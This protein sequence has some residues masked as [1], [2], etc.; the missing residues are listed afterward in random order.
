MERPQRWECRQDSLLYLQNS[1]KGQSILDLHCLN[2]HLAHALLYMHRPRGI[3]KLPA[4]G[5]GARLSAS[6]PDD[7]NYVMRTVC[8]C[9][10][11]KYTSALRLPWGWALLLIHVPSQT[12]P[13]AQTLVGLV[14]SV[15]RSGSCNEAGL[16]S[17]YVVGSDNSTVQGSGGDC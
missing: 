10:R 2:I 11:P 9:G 14:G 8:G 7:E 15:L 5:R 13:L 3:K 16:V 12:L 1:T 17:V 6:H 4:R